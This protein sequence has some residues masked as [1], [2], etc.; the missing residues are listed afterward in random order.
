MFLSLNLEPEEEL[1]LLCARTSLTIKIESRIYQLIENGINWEKLNYISAIHGLKPLFYY[2]IQK[3]DKNF[4]NS[5]EIKE[6]LLY[7]SQ[8]NLFLMSEM[9]KVV[10]KLNEHNINAIPYKGPVLS[11]ESYGN[12]ALRE[13][14]D[15]DIYICESDIKK[16]IKI[17]NNLGYLENI[18]IDKSKEAYY[19]KTQREVK[20]KN[21]GAIIE[22]Q[23][24]VAGFSFS[25]PNAKSFPIDNKFREFKI[26]N[27]ILNVFS[28]EEMLLI[29]SIHVAGHLWQRLIW[30]CDIT[31]LIKNSKEVNWNC[32]LEKAKYLG[33]ERVLLINLVLCRDLFDLILPEIVIN[34]IKNDHKVEKLE[35]QILKL[36]FRPENINIWERLIIRFGM[37]EKWI[38]GA[39]DIIRIITIPQSEEWTFFQKKGPYKLLYLI[40]R[41]IQLI[42]RIRE[43]K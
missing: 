35:K 30:I 18:K 15:V 43:G 22:L 25:F 14:E 23:W 19:L 20:L 3:F 34:R 42:K 11:I 21:N 10:K 26:N 24:N 40:Q 29:L 27:T 2:N 36:I 6:Y 4:Y 37:R 7:N 16:A 38:N 41:P 28:H 8:K 9:I 1:I 12:V 5:S 31:K 33:I 13:F 39:I 17:L 32:I